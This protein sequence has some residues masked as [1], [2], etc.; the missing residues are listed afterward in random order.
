MRS[1]H[2]E[3]CYNLNNQTRS[4]QMTLYG[5]TKLLELQ[6]AFGMLC[7]NF[8]NRLSKQNVQNVYREESVLFHSPMRLEP[9]KVCMDLCE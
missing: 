7:L 8:S 3:Q 6:L 9:L 1:G 2:C 5:E 4:R